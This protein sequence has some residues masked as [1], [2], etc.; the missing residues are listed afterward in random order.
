MQNIGNINYS[1]NKND[2]YKIL[3]GC[4]LVFIPFY[5]IVV[6]ISLIYIFTIKYSQYY[7]SNRIPKYKL[8]QNVEHYFKSIT[9]HSPFDI[10]S[11]SF[12]DINN[13]KYMGLSNISYIIIL[14]S[15]LITFF[16]ILQGLI[17]NFLYSVYSNIIQV[18]LNNNPYNNPNNVSKINVSPNKSVVI[19]YFTIVALSLVFLIPFTIP[20]II[21][22][23]KF[24]NYNIKHNV[25]FAYLLLLLIFSPVIIIISC[26]SYFNTKLSIFS[27]LNQYLQSN[28]YSFINYITDNFNFKI[29]SILPFLFIV[30]LFCYYQFIY[31]QVNFYSSIY[32]KIAAY[33]ILFLIIFVFLPTIILFFSFSLLFDN[34]TFESGDDI[35]ENIKKNGISS[36]YDLLVKYNYPCFRK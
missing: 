2:F 32:K 22:F 36:L 17:R 28:D 27:N 26:Y 30:F 11:L 6:F 10:M 25:W 23:L 15:Y 7:Y 19:N 1:L 8:N 4:V 34:K 33:S 5:Y 12:Q 13:N 3:I 35:I 16:I 24:D 20:Y 21:K 29:Y 14:F 18:N 9:Y 31:V